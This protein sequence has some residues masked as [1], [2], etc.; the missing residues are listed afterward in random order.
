MRTMFEDG[1]L[2]SISGETTI[3]E[4]KRVAINV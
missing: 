3:D 2:K 4:I 1:M